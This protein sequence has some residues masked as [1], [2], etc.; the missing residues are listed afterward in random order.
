[1]P[2]CGIEKL[3]VAK[4]LTDT[5]SGMTFTQP[6][7][8]PMVQELDI[9]P[10]VNTASAYAE[11]RKVDQATLFDSADVSISRYAM[12]SA[13]RAFI[14]GQTLTNTGGSVSSDIDE[15]PYVALLYKAPIKT[16]DG[17]N[18][19]RYGVIYKTMFTPPDETLKGLEGKPDLSEVDKVAGSAQPTEWSFKDNGGNEKH[20]WEYHVD[21]T[22]PGC[23]EN[24]DDTW[25]T[26]VPIPTIATPDVLTLSSSNPANNATGVILTV[27]P[28]LTFN[29][30]ITGYLST[31][32]LNESDNSLVANTLS[33]DITGKILTITPSTNLVTG[34]TYDIILTGVTDLYGQ[35]LTQ[36]IIKFTTA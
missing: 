19:Y 18:A 31:V 26:S 28:A 2:K 1:M 10:K 13:E 7:Y 6:T 23:P 14:L 20:P 35:V 9:K 15:A 36:Q 34:K 12:T 25:F 3:Y 27:K 30:A 17:T 32:L 21:T 24:I 8:Y 5:T 16:A 33:L 11:N 29:N 22:D 4:Q